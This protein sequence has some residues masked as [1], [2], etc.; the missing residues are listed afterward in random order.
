MAKNTNLNLTIRINGKEVKNTLSSVQKEM[1]KLKREVAKTTRGTDEYVK[2]SAELKKVTKVWKKMKEEITGVPTLLDKVKDKFGAVGTIAGGIFA[3]ERILDYAKAIVTSINELRKL[4]NT[5]RQITDLN[6][7]A[8]D[9]ATAKIKSLSTAF[10]QDTKKMTEAAN[11]L[12]K[13]MGVDFS[14]ALDLIEQGFLDGA[15]AN[16]DFLDKVRE[17]PALL[18]EVGLSAQES[19]ALMTQEVKQG[20][21]SDKGVD[22]IKEANLRLREMTPAAQEALTAIGLSSKNI[23]KELRDGSKTTFDVIQ[24]VSKRMAS[25][26]PQSK[27]VGQA[28][29][30]IFGGPGEDAGIKYLSN[31]YKIDLS[32]GNITSQTDD[33]TRAKRLEV[34]ANE[35]L[36]NVWVKLTGT[37]STLSVIYN[38]FKL[39][40]ADLLA[41][42]TGVKDEALE[43]QKA[44]D[45]Q[46]KSVINLDKNLLPLLDEYDKLKSKT[47]LTKEEQ[48]RLKKVISKIGGIVPTAITAFDDYGNALDIS[49]GKAKDFIETQKILLSYKNAEVIE[50]QTDK[51][52]NLNKE[53]EKN[54]R[55]LNNRNEEG[56]IVKV[57]HTFTKTDRL[58]VSEEKVSGKEIARLQARQTEIQNE[59][60]KHQTILDAHN[61][62]YLEKAIQKQTQQ[63]EKTSEQIEARKVLEQTASKYRIKFTSETSDKELQIE[64]DKA[65]ERANF[66]A[67]K[68]K[69]QTE[70]EQKEAEARRKRLEKQQADYL[71][72]IATSAQALAVKEKEAHQQRLI[73]A[74]LFGKDRATLTKTQLELLIALEKEHRTNIAK[75]PIQLE[76]AAYIKRQKQAGIYLKEDKDLNERQLLVKETLLAQHQAKLAKIDLDATNKHLSSKKKNHDRGITILKTAQANELAE[77][78][79]LEGAKS[80]LKDT[81]GVKDLSKIDTLEKA[82]SELKKQ[83]KLK[84]LEAQGNYLKSIVKLYTEALNNGDI[85]GLGFASK[86]L[87]EEQKEILN[88]QLEQVRLKLAEVNAEKNG[89][90]GESTDLEVSDTSDLDFF[91]MSPEQWEQSF[92]NLDTAKGKITAL[93]AVVSGL[94][95]AYSLYNQFVSN[96]EAKQLKKYEKTV[97][98]K[99]AALERQKETELNN[100]KLS[101]KEREAIR[102]KYDAQIE[103]LDNDLAKKRAD[104]EYKQAKRSKQIALMEAVAGTAAGVA[105]ALPNIPLAI[106]AGAMGAL[107][108]GLIASAPLPDRG[109]KDGGFTQ[110]L[111]YKDHTGEEVA[112]VVHADEYVIPKFVMNS[113]D[114]AVPQVIQYLEH[115]RK[116]KLGYFNTGGHTST[117]APTFTEES[118][119]TTETSSDV[120]MLFL[121][122]FT[123]LNNRLDEGI[124]SNA[125]IG[126]DEIYRYQERE[127]TLN[128]SREN[129]KVQ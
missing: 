87:T 129:A 26:P 43:A 53:L 7:E 121:E 109:Y 104:L 59:I 30:D 22:A 39:G 38:S 125:L 1:Y 16:G 24:M 112:G 55:I 36:N 124:N 89:T 73:E 120:M 100:D 116:E 75:I 80:L 78:T 23:Q 90:N 10:D 81:Y 35:A 11:N 111:G 13:Q 110:S 20:I 76:K 8:L 115:K 108:I 51:L 3:A 27:L 79:S 49:T 34:K 70:R 117:P 46:A 107:Q 37:G 103:K 83:H 67:G 45:E 58:I 93:S 82:K 9:Q 56:D 44:F 62:D 71:E 88:E 57:K 60:K 50:E 127:E 52:S 85:E 6:G 98:S 5:I 4:K 47:S 17:Y 94:A 118:E 69:E 40:L 41:T 74:D 91:G 102:K 31:L 42:I 106:L 99:I 66:L 72:K 21:Y 29:A 65:I 119:T 95:N 105:K 19:I 33:Y 92:S 2:K 14:E 32:L 113:T 18:Q 96:A 25:L 77:I 64:I 61:G 15:D 54:K 101:A 28:I 12:S 97:N 68:R 122:Q 86:I 126:D 63:T 48:D 123:R 128:N 114:P 84:E